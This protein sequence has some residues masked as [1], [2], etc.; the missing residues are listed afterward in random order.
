MV[1]NFII[2]K[3]F[4][5]SCFPVIFLKLLRRPTLQNMSEQMLES[6]EPKT[7]CIHKSYSQESSGDGVLFMAAADRWVYSFS[8]TDSMMLFYENCGASQ[9]II[10][11]NTAARLLL[12]SCNN[13]ESSLAL[14][15]INQFSH[16]QLSRTFRKEKCLC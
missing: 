4:Q 7:N 1:C 15:V 12:I 16:S 3:R 10:F 14:S 6:N 8:K 13:F 5:H 11:T 2:K 9:S